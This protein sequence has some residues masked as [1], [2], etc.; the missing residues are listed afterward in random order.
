MALSVLGI[1]LF[2][3]RSGN[4]PHMH[5][6]MSAQGRLGDAGCKGYGYDALEDG[7]TV[8]GCCRCGDH[9][10]VYCMFTIGTGS[11]GWKMHAIVA[12]I[13]CVILHLCVDTQAKILYI[14]M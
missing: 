9:C 10:Y 12:C 5:Q 1:L 4:L 6:G 13:L 11:L 7:E 2:R 8:G 14:K 3:S